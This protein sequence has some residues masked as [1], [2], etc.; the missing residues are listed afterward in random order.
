MEALAGINFFNFDNA[1]AS[2]T[3]WPDRVDTEWPDRVDAESP[4]ANEP[5]LNSLRHSMPVPA[6]NYIRQY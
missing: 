6:K 4:I 5:I 1:A 3:E 2:P